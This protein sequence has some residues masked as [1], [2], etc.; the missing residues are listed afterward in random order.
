M[1][2]LSFTKDLNT[3]VAIWFD[4]IYDPMPSEYPYHFYGYEYL[5]EEDAEQMLND[6]CTSDDVKIALADA[7]DITA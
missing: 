6:P 5:T 7:L 4:L 1:I 3:P 2:Q